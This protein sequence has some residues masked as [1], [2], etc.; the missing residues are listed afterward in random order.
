M[1]CLES[2]HLNCIKITRDKGGNFYQVKDA[3][4]CVQCGQCDKVCPL[5][6]VNNLNY[7]NKAYIAWNKNRNLNKRSAS[8]GIAVAIY[9]YCL[10]NGIICVGVKF[11]SNQKAR[12]GIISDLKELEMYVSSKYVYSHMGKIYIKI[13]NLLRKGEKVLFIGLPC[14]V[15]AL[16]KWLHQEYK[17]LFLVDLVCHG[18][19]PENIL[20][21]HI[22]KF[23]GVCKENI[24]NICFREADNQYGI[25]IKGKNNQ[26]LKKITKDEDKYMI[27]FCNGISYFEQCY[28]CKYARKERCSDITLKDF[29]G[30]KFIKKSFFH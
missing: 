5:I 20:L 14:H 13:L 27:A 21:K 12:Y 10:Q 30:K 15:S 11:D 22:Y 2:C 26:I 9:R 3:S 16:K 17:N 1:A 25:T 18:T 23:K 28:M 6:D 29:S 24:G 8:G 4:V 19:V 7:P